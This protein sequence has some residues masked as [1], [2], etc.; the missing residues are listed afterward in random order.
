MERTENSTKQTQEKEG[1]RPIIAVDF[2][3]TL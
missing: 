1:R 2:D 3:G